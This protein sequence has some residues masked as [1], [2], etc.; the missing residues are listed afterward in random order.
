[1]LWA[2]GV[3][4]LSLSRA[5]DSPDRTEDSCGVTCPPAGLEI[6]ADCKNCGG[7][8]ECYNGKMT[9]KTCPNSYLYDVHDKYC[10]EP[11]QV[12]C[13]NRPVDEDCTG[14]NP[15][16]CPFE[17]GYIKDVHNCRRYFECTDG[18]A[19]S[20]SCSSPTSDGLYD[21]NHEQCKP[22]DEVECK[23][24][25]ICTGHPP[26]YNHCQCQGAE[27][28]TEVGCPN[29]N[30]VEFIT[31]PFN[32]QHGLVCQEG[33]L[34][35]DVFC[36]DGTFLQPDFTCEEGDGSVCE[37]RPICNDKEKSKDCYCYHR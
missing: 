36:P 30:N 8:L 35:Q 6:F 21:Y 7:Y 19:I 3:V 1:M 29:N 33:S 37:G 20:M 9:T 27:I 22:P 16:D 25:P 15:D 18:V 28:V 34:V 12:E 24:R 2:C 4:F 32:C 31:D 10:K 17:Y 14:T 11:T 23:E 5:Q 13:G 26:E